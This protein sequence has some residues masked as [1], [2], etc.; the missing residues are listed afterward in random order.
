MSEIERDE[1]REK[2]SVKQIRRAFA[3]HASRD[4]W[5]VE[6]H[7]ETTLISALRGEFDKKKAQP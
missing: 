6:A 2:Y 3:K 4:D 7:Y 5:G 1:K